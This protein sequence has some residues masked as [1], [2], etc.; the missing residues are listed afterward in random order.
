MHETMQQFLDWMA[1]Q[2]RANTVPSYTKGLT[3]YVEWLGERAP[4]EVTLETLEAFQRHLFEDYRRRDTRRPLKLSTQAT[5]LSAV[6]GYYGY[7]AR[8]RLIAANPSRLLKLP[9]V[10]RT[11]V[12]AAALDQQ[13]VM[14]ILALQ[15][16]RVKSKREGAL[17]WASEVRTLALL[18]LAFA[19]GRRRDGLHNLKVAHLDFERNEIRV[20]REKGRH[21]RVLPCAQWALDAARVYIE[22]ARQLLVNDRPDP[23]WLFINKKARRLNGEYLGRKL[24]LLQ[25][26]TAEA[27]PDLDELAAKRLSTHSTRVTFAKNLMFLNGASLRVVNELLLH[28]RLQTT[29]RYTPLELDDLRRACRSAHPRA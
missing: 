21:G 24:R 4:L 17:G 15:A 8:L 11:R 16:Q 3:R 13:E 5:W 22:Q 19:T 28:R 18:A 27:N 9:K 12:R 25:V 2:G 14:A 29:T 10:P 23:G 26:L 6:K 20:E 7:L 1:T